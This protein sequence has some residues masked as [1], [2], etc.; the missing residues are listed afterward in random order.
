MHVYQFCSITLEGR[1]TA[2]RDILC[3]DDAEA[4]LFAKDMSMGFQ[5][6]EVWREARLIGSAPAS[7]VPKIP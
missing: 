3:S 4:L 6:V 2:D 1:N 5:S 7:H